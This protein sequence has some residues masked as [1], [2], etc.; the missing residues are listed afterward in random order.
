MVS[1]RRSSSRN[2][3]ARASS[4]AA[5]RSSVRARIEWIRP[6]CRSPGLPR[7]STTLAISTRGAEYARRDFT[8]N[9]VDTVRGTAA[10]LTTPRA[11]REIGIHEGPEHL[12]H[13]RPEIDWFAEHLPVVLRVR[14]Q[15]GVQVAGYAAGELHRRERGDSFEFHVYLPCRAFLGNSLAST[16]SQPESASPSRYVFVLTREPSERRR[17]R[18]G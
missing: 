11:E 2:S 4:V 3:V 10:V 6:V 15:I 17:D 7:L 9:T 16:G 5:S 13:E 18:S 8:L 1:I 12:N 14:D